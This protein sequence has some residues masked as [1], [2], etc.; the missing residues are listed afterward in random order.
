MKNILLLLI[1][2][3]GIQ[4]LVLSQSREETLQRYSNG[5]KSLVVTYV[6][7]GNNEK[8]IKRNY[9]FENGTKKI[10]ENIK[11]GKLH[12]R[13][14]TWNI[15]GQILTDEIY[16][17]GNIKEVIK[18]CQYFKNG[19]LKYLNPGN[20]EFNVYGQLISEGIGQSR[21]EYYKNGQLKYEG[22]GNT[23]KEYYYNGQLK[24][25]GEGNTRKEYYEN[26]QLKTDGN[27]E[28]YDNGQIKFD[29]LYHYRKDGL[30][31]PNN[32]G[33]LVAI[34]S[35]WDQDIEIKNCEFI[36]NRD[37]SMMSDDQITAELSVFITELQFDGLLDKGLNSYSEAKSCAEWY[38]PRIKQK[39]KS[40][41]GLD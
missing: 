12:G 28:Y 6:G 35:L 20:K 40:E 21:K 10:E 17:N 8:I 15:N 39:C 30:K 38:I 7:Q 11:Y 22:E 14:K 31:L 25:E 36:T 29:S 19:Q 23:R 37:G 26:G 5:E 34:Q 2:L 33:A 18:Q 16:E 24:Y 27:V 32:V 3:I 4:N 9:Y 1:L 13:K 41:N